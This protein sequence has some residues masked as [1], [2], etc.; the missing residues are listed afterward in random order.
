MIVS[1][2]TTPP[3]RTAKIVIDKE[4]QWNTQNVGRTISYGYYQLSL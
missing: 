1:K 2:N 3:N 4:I